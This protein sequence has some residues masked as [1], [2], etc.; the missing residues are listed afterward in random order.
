M[1]ARKDAAVEL[2]EE[3]KSYELKS[4]GLNMALLGAGASRTVSDALRRDLQELYDCSEC[5]CLSGV[6]LVSVPIV[7][8]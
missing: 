2:L 1:T 5:S 7:A 4:Y 6:I 8:P 3:L